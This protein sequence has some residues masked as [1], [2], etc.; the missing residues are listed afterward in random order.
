LVRRDTSQEEETRTVIIK[1]LP[2]NIKRF[3]RFNSP[4]DGLICINTSGFTIN[5]L[6]RDLGLNPRIFWSGN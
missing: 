6:W 1:L 5:A 4:S 3:A 2:K